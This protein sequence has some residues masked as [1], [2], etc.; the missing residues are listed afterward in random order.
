VTFKPYP[1][2]EYGRAN[3]N[4]ASTSVDSV[5][6][7]SLARELHVKAAGLKDSMPKAF[8]TH[9]GNLMPASERVQLLQKRF[10]SNS[11][12]RT[13]HTHLQMLTQQLPKR[14]AKLNAL[15]SGGPSVYKLQKIA[16]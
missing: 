14:R 8:A 11:P 4:V 16:G 7:N 12:D 9:R 13:D 6:V 1:T 15:G 2:T 5:N 10:A 3:L